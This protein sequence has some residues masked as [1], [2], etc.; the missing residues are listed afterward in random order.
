[1]ELTYLN[2]QGPEQAPVK[3]V[4]NKLKMSAAWMQDGVA[5]RDN[6]RGPDLSITYVND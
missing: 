4:S 2:R 6:T 3:E 5:S 1:V